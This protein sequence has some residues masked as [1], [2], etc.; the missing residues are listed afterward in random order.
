VKGK[1]FWFQILSFF[2]SAI[3]FA[4]RTDGFQKEKM[5][6]DSLILCSAVSLCLFLFVWRRYVGRPTGD[7]LLAIQQAIDGNYQARFSCY[8]E[9]DNFRQL[10]FAFNRL[11]GCVES[12][13][14]EL[15]ASRRLQSQLYENEKIYRSA[16]ELTCE[17]V[18]E[19]DLTH[20]RLIYG[21]ETYRKKL[22]FSEN[23]KTF[24]DLI[25]NL[26]ERIVYEEDIQ[27]FLDAFD[28]Q[29][30]LKIFNGSDTPEIFLEY[31]QKLPSGEVSWVSA[32]IIRSG[33]PEDTLKVIGY[34]KNINERKKQELE[35]LKQSQKD[36]LTGIYNRRCTQS[37]IESY[38]AGTGSKGR[39]AA[40]ML[41][42]DDF[43]LVNDTFGHAQGG[44][45]AL[46]TVAGNLSSLFRKTD[47]V[48]RIGGDE[49]FVLM[50]D[51]SSKETLVEKLKE[52]SEMFL[53]IHLKEDP[54][55]RIS[56]SIGIALY[57]E[58]GT[59]YETLYKKADAALY[60]CKAHGKNQ[61]HVY[62]RRTE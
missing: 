53:K 13:T 27:R 35:I 5:T 46:S 3:F 42:I 21:F 31:R 14:E 47:I 19:A 62:S 6:P 55:F 56:G 44:D 57:P 17:R 29:N 61:F 25:R 12:Q 10:S 48:G 26:A 50:K 60:Y 40:M 59:D 22:E 34:V 32:S 4:Y 38:L 28:R 39:H 24:E 20:N 9:N 51:Y 52:L 7:F 41:D 43:K 23:V 18:F 15:I 2:L 8:A 33:N 58:D 11:M 36:G 54:S 49:F 16:L 45:A 30:L 1:S 37:L